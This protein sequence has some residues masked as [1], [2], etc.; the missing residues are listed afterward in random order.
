MINNKDRYSISE[1]AE[2][3]G[4]KPHVIR[5]YE[6]EFKLEIPRAE[7]S[8]RYFTNK[9]VDLLLYIKQLQQNGLSNKEIKKVLQDQNTGIDSNYTKSTD[10]D[11]NHIEGAAESY[12]G[13]GNFNEDLKKEILMILEKYNYR[14]E[15]NELKEKLEELAKQFNVP[16]VNKDKDVLICENAKLKMKIKEK[17]YEVAE[18]KDKLKRQDAQRISIFHR[19]LRTKAESNI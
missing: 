12:T 16:D 9:E 19:L 13:T 5:F 15:I 2:H 17:S 1:V 11:D 8:R 3:I 6:K 4:F 14:S 10:S 7:N 18:L